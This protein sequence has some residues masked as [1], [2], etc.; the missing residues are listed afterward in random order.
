M[1]LSK[2]TLNILKNFASI[3]P[4]LFLQKGNVIMTKSNTNTI[5]AEVKVDD[6]IDADIGIYDVA[7]FLSTLN[8]FTEDFE[9]T[10][11]PVDEEIT[12][13]DSRSR[14]KYTICDPSLIVRPSQP[15]RFPVADV[16][17]DL[18]NEDLTQVLKAA[19]T[20]GLPELLV[21]NENDR[22]VIKAVNSNDPSAN[23]YALDI[24]EF[25]NPNNLD[26]SFYILVENMKMVKGDYSVKISKLGA[27]LFENSAI[28]YIVALE[29][30]S[31]CS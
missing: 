15:A 22:I 7:E 8:L 10:A 20:L 12:I 3:N 16:L 24:A 18:K 30:N 4:S 25:D 6:V 31:K 13:K 28:K 21:T 23:A 26:F 14:V 2:S 17:F 11:S 1:K 9:I 27:V 29:E 5:Y 19:I